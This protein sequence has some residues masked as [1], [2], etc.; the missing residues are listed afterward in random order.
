MLSK[1]DV[2]KTRTHKDDAK[3]TSLKNKIHVESD[4]KSNNLQD[5]LMYSYNPLR[6]K[7]KQ[8]NN[9]MI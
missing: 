3:K 7:E 4:I 1:R 2:N 6:K 8:D 5:Q 9:D